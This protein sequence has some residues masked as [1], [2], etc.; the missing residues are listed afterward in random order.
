M[1]ALMLA[2]LLAFLPRLIRRWRGLPPT[3][4]KAEPVMGEVVKEDVGPVDSS[5]NV[6][7]KMTDLR[8]LKP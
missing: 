2:A 3:D 6:R 1:M 5:F 7:M 8:P 4:D